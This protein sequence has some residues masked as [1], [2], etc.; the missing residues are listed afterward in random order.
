MTV[1]EFYLVW[2]NGELIKESKLPDREKEVFLWFIPAYKV[3]KMHFP[4]EGVT[5]V[6]RL[7]LER[8]VQSIIRT[9]YQ[10]PDHGRIGLDFSTEETK[11]TDFI[12]DPTFISSDVLT[13]AKWRKLQ[14]ERAKRT[15]GTLVKKL[16]FL[17]INDAVVHVYTHLI[18]VLDAKSEET[19]T[20]F[21][22]SEE[23]VFVEK[24]LPNIIKMTLRDGSFKS[25]K[26]D[27]FEPE[28]EINTNCMTL[29]DVHFD[30]TRNKGFYF[31][32]FAFGEF[33]IEVEKNEQKISLKEPMSCMHAICGVLDG[34]D[35]IIGFQSGAVQRIFSL[36]K[37]M[38][39]EAHAGGS[40]LSMTIFNEYLL[41]GQND[42]TLR[43][44]NKLTGSFLRMW[45]VTETGVTSIIAMEED[46]IVAGTEDSILVCMD[47]IR[48]QQKWE[49]ELKAGAV[50]SISYDKGTGI[51]TVLT[52]KGAIAQIDYKTG[53]LEKKVFQELSFSSNQLYMTNKWRAYGAGN[54][55]ILANDQVQET[56]PTGKSNIR[57]I[58]QYSG[59]IILGTI[60]GEL[61][62]WKRIGI[63]EL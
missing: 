10:D 22:I 37:E 6:A 12:K 56:I 13:P 19:L 47:L 48:E 31:G 29:N 33:S 55:L 15:R 8:Q 24:I 26:L 62:L 30:Q 3:I 4:E 1:E 38:Q 50:L 39:W 49:L 16:S 23:I 34:A 36:T 45:T 11:D 60:T 42:G 17:N 27:F 18:D 5:K 57:A 2:K 21:E 20:L 14:D 25:F 54:N 51:V 35:P 41:T 9:G 7:S 43:K 46:F 40:V 28:F 63:S 44:F 61:Y 52:K 32:S 58:C 53:K 59:G